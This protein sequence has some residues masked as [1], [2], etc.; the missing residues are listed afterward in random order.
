MRA[1]TEGL[2][3]RRSEA[4]CSPSPLPWEK[5]NR[6]NIIGGDGLI[7][8]KM[9]GVGMLTDANARVMESVG[10][11]VALAVRVKR[12]GMSYPAYDRKLASEILAKIYPE[13]AKDHP[14]PPQPL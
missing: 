9:G 14:T 12:G 4:V 10:E 2:I 7:V 13:N 5:D 3:A 1:E 8:A 6:G 11:L